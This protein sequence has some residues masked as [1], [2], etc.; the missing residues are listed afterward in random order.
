MLEIT[1]YI[2]IKILMKPLAAHVQDLSILITVYLYCVVGL[3]AGWSSLYS[4]AIP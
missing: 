4:H 3:G 1:I 2:N